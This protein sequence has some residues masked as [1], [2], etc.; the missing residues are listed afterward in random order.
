MVFDADQTARTANIYG[1]VRFRPF[2]QLTL[3]A[4][5]V[6]ADGFRKRRVKDE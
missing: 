2:E 6:Y 3:I 4:G 1:E 5:G